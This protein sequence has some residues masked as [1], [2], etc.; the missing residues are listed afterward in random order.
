MGGGGVGTPRILGEGVLPGSPN[1]D[2]I[3]DQNM[4]FSTLVFRPGL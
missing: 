4:S 2:P 1:P 3:T